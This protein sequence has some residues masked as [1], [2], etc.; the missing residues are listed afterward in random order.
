LLDVVEFFNF[1]FQIVVVRSV[2]FDISRVFDIVFA[3]RELSKLELVPSLR[4][5]GYSVKTGNVQHRILSVG[6]FAIVNWACELLQMLITNL[7]RAICHLLAQR[8]TRRT[9]VSQ[10]PAP[11]FAVNAADTA[12][13]LVAA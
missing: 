11:F 5:S 10:A 8:F 4:A 9:A 13:A 2:T 6:A 1:D 3:I 12:P 7:S